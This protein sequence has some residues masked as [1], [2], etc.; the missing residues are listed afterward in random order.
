MII[1]RDM[2]LCKR[3]VWENA[4]TCSS[5][6]RVGRPINL[7]IILFDN[8]VFF[9]NSVLVILSIFSEIYQT[10]ILKFEK[11]NIY[12][13]NVFFALECIYLFLPFNFVIC[14]VICEY[15]YI[16]KHIPLTN[17]RSVP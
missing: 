4:Y 13:K 3:W 9:Q 1:R 17:L 5:L 15:I 10:N 7:Y 8:H 14:Q 12:C 6:K 11:I 16:L 2:H